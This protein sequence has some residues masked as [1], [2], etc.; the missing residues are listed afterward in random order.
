MVIELHFLKVGQ[1]TASGSPEG[2]GNDNPSLLLSL[3]ASLPTRL[4][5]LSLQISG[6]HSP[7]GPGHAPVHFRL[8][9]WSSRLLQDEEEEG[10]C[11]QRAGNSRV[12]R[13]RA[14]LSAPSGSRPEAAHC[15]EAQHMCLL[16]SFNEHLTNMRASV[17]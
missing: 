8:F 7:P 14:P 10:R 1:A 6:E 9:L 15:C 11:S 4:P 16:A 13:T 2:T 12:S 17:S 3:L 5:C